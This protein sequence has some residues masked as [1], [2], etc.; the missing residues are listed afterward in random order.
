MER[1]LTD[2]TLPDVPDVPLADVTPTPADVE[3]A[4]QAA[5]PAPL[6]APLATDPSLFRRGWLDREGSGKF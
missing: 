5:A 1:E 6:S 3:Q 2:V 4:L